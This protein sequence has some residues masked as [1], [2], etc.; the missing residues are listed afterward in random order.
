MKPRCLIG[1]VVLATPV[2]MSAQGASPSRQKQ[3]RVA[4]HSGNTIAQAGLTF[5][6]LNRNGVLDPY[7]DWR[8]SLASAR[9]TS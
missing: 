3:P 7:E 9:A 2:M 8:L 4:S 1:L 5:K 6:D